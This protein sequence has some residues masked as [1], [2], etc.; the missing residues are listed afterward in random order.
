[1]GPQLSAARS[2]PT[3]QSPDG[4]ISTLGASITALVRS[5]ARRITWRSSRR[6]PGQ[7]CA[8]SLA[9]AS[10]ARTRGPISDLKSSRKCWARRSTSPGRSRKAGS[11]SSKPAKRWNRSRR[12]EPRRVS[13]R[14]SRR[15]VATTRTSTA[16]SP[17][18]PTRRICP[19]SSARKSLGCRSMGSSPISSST[20][21]PPD[22]SS[23]QPGRRDPAPVKAPRSCPKSW[24]SAN[25]RARVPQLTA[26]NGPLG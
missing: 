25:S 15:V 7:S 5:A 4:S 11:L 23:N 8:S 12:N 26:T 24:L 6:L 17:L 19:V 13:R 21:V 3:A 9:A 22:A 10:V 14:K 2:I 20:S 18:P 16:V 1:M